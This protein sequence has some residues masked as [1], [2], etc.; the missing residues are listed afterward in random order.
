MSKTV[1]ERIVSMQ[2]DNKHFESNVAMSMSTLDKLKQKL[3][4]SDTSKGLDNLNKS[5]KNVDMSGLGTAVETVRTRFSALEVMGVTALA[6][7]TNSA[8]NAGK[9]MVSALTIDPVKTGFSEYETKI[10]S[11]QTIMSNTASKGTTM[12][13]VTRVIDELNTYADKT[14]YNFAEMTRNI[15]TFTAAGVGLEESAAAIQGIA[16]LAAASGSTSQQASTAMYQLS[17]ALAAGTVKLMDW[18]SVVNAG[19][20]GEKFQEAL[21][22]TA[23]DHGVAVDDIIKKNGSFRDSLQEGW[24][25]ADILNETLNKFTVDGAKNYAKSMVDAGKWTK[26]QADALVK[27]A[28]SMEDAAT[29]VKT[30]TQLWDTLKESAQSGWGKTWELIFGDFEEAKEL[31]SGLSDFLGGFINKISDARNFIVEGVMNIADPWKRIMEKLDGAGLGGI[32][33]ITEAVSNA[34][35]KLEYFQNIVDKV[36]HGDY[37]NADTGRYELLAA[38]GYDS[39]VVQDLVN[40]GLGYK[41]T[42]EDIEASH[43]KFGL[44]METTTKSTEKATNVLANL[45]DEQ[46]RNAGLTDD[47]IRLYRDLAEEAERTGVSIE[48][49]VDKMSKKDGRTLLIESFKNAGN[50][51]VGVFKAIK[52]AWSEIFPAPSIVRIYNIIAAINEFSEKLVLVDKETG[53][54]TDTAKKF[55]RIFEGV[56]ALLDIITTILGGAFK[57]AFKIGAALL[58]TFGLSIVD[59]LVYVADAIVA[60]RDWVDSLIDFKAIAGKIAPVIKKVA[61]VVG[62][63][64]TSIKNSGDTPKEI[65]LNIAKGIK[66]GAGYLGSALLNLGKFLWGKFDSILASFGIDTSGFT[67]AL[68]NSIA[69]FK[70]WIAQLKESDNIPRDIILGLVK[71][72]GEGVKMVATAAI[73]LGKYLLDAIKDFLGIH[74]PASTF[75]EVAKYCILGLVQGFKEGAVWVWDAVKTIANKCLDIIKELDL[76]AVLTVAMVGGLLI[77]GNKIGNAL[78]SFSAPFEGVGDVL[79]ATSNTMKSFSTAIK[80][81]ALM[82]IAQ[83]IAVL[84]A[85]VIALSFIEPA[86]LWGSIGAIAALAVIL[87]GLSAVMGKF[88]AT[89]GANLD[90]AKISLIF[91]SISAALLLMSIALKKM[92]G[93]DKGA[94]EQGMLGIA[95][96]ALMIEILVATSKFTGKGIDGLGATILKI[97]A[98]LVLMVIVVKMLG[99]IEEKTLIRGGIAI[100]AFVGV[101]AL[102]TLITKIAGKD[103]DELG[104]TLIKMAA[105]MLLMTIVVKSLGKMD[106][107]TLIQGGTAILAFVGII[108]LMTL[109]TKIAGGKLIGDVGDVIIKFSAALLLM[110]IAVGILGTMD[111][112][113]LI[114]GGIAILAFVG[115]IALMTLITKLVGKN[116]MDKLGKT[117]IS[118]ALA[119]GIM[120]GAAALL[121]LMDIKTLAKGVGAVAILTG[122]MSLMVF[123]TSNAKKCMGNLIVM[124]VA[125]ALLAASVGVLSTID[126]TKLATATGAMTILMGMFSL[127]ILTASKGA[128]GM[129]ALITLTVAIGVLGGLLYLLSGLPTEGVLTSA[130]AISAI[131]LAMSAAL[132]ILSK[133]THVSASAIVAMAVMGLIV[134]E[135]G[136]ILGLLAHFNVAPSIEMVTSISVML[137]AMSGVLAIL[138]LIGPMASGSFVAMGALAVLIVGIGG[139]LVAL[140]ALMT[141]VPKAQEFLDAGIPVLEKIGYAIGSFFG[142][143]IG[144]FAG[145][146]TDG[147]PKIGE[148]IRA[149]VDSFA[150][151]DS[152]ALDGAKA[153]AGA[154]LALTAANLIEGINSFLGGQS[155]EEFSAQLIPFGKSVVEFSRVLTE[156]GG[157]D[158]AAVEA[159][160]NA[161]SM[162]AAMASNLPNSGGLAGLIMGENDLD[163]FAAKLVPFGKAMVEFSGV[164][165]QGNGIDVAAVEAAANAGKLMTALADTVPNSGG[166][167]G[168]LMGENDIDTF[169]LKLPTFGKA[170]V[171]F[172]NSLTADGAT[173]DQTAI[174]AAAKAGELM[175]TLADKV[176]NSGGALGWLV[177]DN[178]IDTW[179]ARLP[180]FGK[181]MVDFSKTL[182]EGG[183]IDQAAVEGASAAAQ[184]MIALN[185]SIPAGDGVID[186]IKEFFTGSD[187]IA[188]F[189]DQFVVFGEGVVAFSN[190]VKDI[191]TLAVS[192]ASKAGMAMVE[193]ASLLSSNEQAIQVFSSTSTLNLAQFGQQMAS[194]G[195]SLTLFSKTVKGAVD[196]AAVDN[197]TAAGESMISLAKTL[198]GAES[199]I[200]YLTGGTINLATFGQQI[201]SFGSSIIAFSA[202][203]KKGGG[204]RQ[205]SVAS[206]VI[207]GQS[208]VELA[209]TLPG[210]QSAISLLTG[211]QLSL[212]SFGRQM[213]AYGQ[214]IKQFSQIV[215]SGVK[216]TSVTTAVSAG[217]AMTELAKALPTGDINVAKFGKQMASFGSYV[218]KYS[219]QVAG[220]NISGVSKASKV[221]R[222]L[223]DVAKDASNLDAKGFA[224]FGKS[225]GNLGRSGVDAFVK[226]FDNGKKKSS[227]AAVRMLTAFVKG[228]EGRMSL[229]SSAFNKTLSKAITTIRSKYSTFSDAG[230]YLVS[231]FASGISAN[232]YKAAAKARAMAKAAAEA[233]EDELGIESPSKVGYGIG[234]FF[235]IGFINAIGDSARSAYKAGSNMAASARDGL[236]NAVSKVA[237]F[238]NSDMDSQPTIR[239]VLDLSNVETGINT[240]NGMFALN[241]VGVMTNV[242]TISTMMNRRRQNGVN[243]D[244][245]SAID[246]LRKD[247]GSMERNSYNINGISY[248]RGSEVAEAIETIVRAATKERRT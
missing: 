131:L 195:A 157:I 112:E 119:I 78:Q 75:I 235:G 144:G 192:A 247:V 99:K 161:G 64:I 20:G 90:F 113:T 31:F 147:L 222:E 82:T 225:L 198:P 11:I 218:R 197:A 209:K 56:F 188:D 244:V 205:A 95:A 150:G 169:A 204:V 162:I 135:M 93:M 85:S 41:L 126:G 97:S 69:K 184:V 183:G 37:K 137:L 3:K 83:A 104:S 71:G 109:I 180:T 29:K 24:I 1:D 92:G 223:I 88:G 141:E 128:S 65:L 25:T 168:W 61:G 165:T 134:A 152:S 111:R 156:G 60:V 27:E 136:I 191:D 194:F 201:V 34:A 173:I 213:V 96:L 35:D 66:N 2:F 36:W 229:I 100:L 117:L 146:L 106:R 63:L 230:S 26:E 98:A 7:I 175:T 241:P 179:A 46:L 143:I 107:G 196:Q 12:E 4:F 76:G 189:A 91:I 174:E 163:T 89:G 203:M 234:D 6:N 140:G 231:G 116:D 21:K 47:E 44:T 94:F 160:A 181:A 142:N 178:D 193:F 124:T 70:E 15:G 224:S 217:K 240:M 43:K 123:A 72:L 16:N 237:D 68:S 206:A 245:V 121:G 166:A 219:E 13:D 167:L 101:I 19:M 148:N 202:T 211:G 200:S 130:A 17:Q 40:K 84:A 62:N 208:M 52:N 53:E 176:P 228:I 232:S 8:V 226:A 55:Q 139:L 154:L 129:G 207:A 236:S 138:S 127:V 133:I 74:S 215:G 153:V 22:A 67:S 54:L 227:D 243:D 185:D 103:F 39:R 86:K 242:G 187:D 125:I 159:A 33:K 23:R 10:N 145:G 18:N 199:A 51:L 50:G 158:S 81:K 182:T 115:I 105:A 42:V 233:A 49:L 14:I 221:V 45:S 177:G 110:T 246:K 120:A 57:I 30:F 58:D 38:D 108:A 186:N 164:L 87:G 132:I 210:A 238:L 170:M 149:F 48:D 171:D 5:V 122:M 79:D 32:K 118:M 9:R 248:E 28:E 172:S 77:V 220:I 216:M 151:V 73:K 102:L 214:Y 212:A 80:A 239:P 59:V 155:I 114:Q 190:T